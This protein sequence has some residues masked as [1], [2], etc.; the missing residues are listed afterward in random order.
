MTYEEIIKD[1]TLRTQNVCFN[2]LK[3]TEIEL[4]HL[5]LSSKET[6]SK[7]CANLMQINAGYKKICDDLVYN[8]T[9]KEIREKQ[10][11]T[12]NHLIDA[13]ILKSPE[14]IDAFVSNINVE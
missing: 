13:G 6:M 5:E 1:Y 4:T 12:I 14:Q 10:M 11:S 2:E 3:K 7:L 9:I 8:K